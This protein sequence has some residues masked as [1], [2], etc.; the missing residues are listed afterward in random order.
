MWIQFDQTQ[1]YS[2]HIAW[3]F[4]ATYKVLTPDESSYRLWYCCAYAAC[5]WQLSDVRFQVFPFITLHSASLTHKLPRA[6][7]CC[8]RCCTRK[9]PQ[10]LHNSTRVGGFGGWNAVQHW[11]WFCLVAC[12]YWQIFDAIFGNWFENLISTGGFLFRRTV[13]NYCEMIDLGSVWCCSLI[14]VLFFI[15]VKTH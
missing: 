13:I 1:I 5:G 15:I 3:C 4:C 6:G 11:R 7:S 9:P 12:W 2:H 8:C 10:Q 14:W